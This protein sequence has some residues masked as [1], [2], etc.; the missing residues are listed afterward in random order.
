M[1]AEAATKADSILKGIEGVEL[2]GDLV[3]SARVEPKNGRHYLIGLSLEAVDHPFM[4]SIVADITEC[5]ESWGWE[6]LVT[7]GGGDPAK[8]AEGIKDMVGGGID[9]LMVQAAKAEPLKPVLAEVHD[10]GVPFMFVGKPIKGTD[11]FTIVSPDNCGIGQ[12][13]N[14]R[15]HCRR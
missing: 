12:H 2:R 1:G 8:Q 6:L 15:G 9:L 14:P 11:A 10:Q 5:V 7:D 13:S 4:R 3:P